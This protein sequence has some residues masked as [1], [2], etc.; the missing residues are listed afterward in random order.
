[1][2]DRYSLAP[3][4][5]RE[6]AQI[7]AEV[8]SWFGTASIHTGEIF[9]TNVVPILL[10]EE[11]KIPPKPMTWG[12]HSFKG[13]GVIINARGETALDKPMFRRS[14]LERRCVV[15]T[16]GYYEWDRKK[17]KYRFRLPRRNRL[18]LAGL[19]NVFQ[20]EE[21]FVIL[22]TAPND[23]II[24]VHDRMP[25]LLADDEVTPWL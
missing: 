18:Y 23:S 16:T 19:W 15:P 12:F 6:I 17:T 24:N 21:R 22:T 13:K 10:R 2:C 11:Q 9:P 5:S 8:Q 25:V 14:L 1:M 7:V 20:G 3:D 4:E